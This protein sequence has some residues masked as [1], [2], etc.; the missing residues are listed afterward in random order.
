M[1]NKETPLQHD[2]FSDELVDNRTRRQKRLDRQRD[3]PQQI[4]MF[5][6]R[7]LAQFGVRA[8]PK[9][10]I[11]PTTKME[12]FVQDPRIEEEKER[13]LQRQAEERTYPLPGDG[14]GPNT[15]EEMGE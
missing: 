11:T 12:L 13:D 4:E 14:L 9:F 1:T 3:R 6:Q 7:E 15:M 5:S 2:M 8:N 10:P